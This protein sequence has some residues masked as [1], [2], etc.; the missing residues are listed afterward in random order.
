LTSTASF[1][2][3]AT[4]TPTVA[5]ADL[6]VTKV[7]SPVTL[8]PGDALTYTLTIGN[9]G[10]LTA[11]GV[12]VTDS[13]PATVVLLTAAASQ[14]TCSGTTTVVCSLGSL[15][16]SGSATV[17]LMV[18]TGPV[19]PL[20]NTASVRGNEPDPDPSNDTSSFAVNVGATAIP[21]VSDKGL[22]VFAVL[23]AAAAVFVLRRDL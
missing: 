6:S 19:G 1:T 8:N 14:G 12:T 20:F 7:G 3:T 21:A 9:A 2:A 17:T 13:L 22:L 15:V 5:G 10:P 18:R 4:A 11:T 23:L 16:P